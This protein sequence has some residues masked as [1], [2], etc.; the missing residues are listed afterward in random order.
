MSNKGTNG[1]K[2]QIIPERLY[3]G[4]QKRTLDDMPLAFACDDNDTDIKRL[5]DEWAKRS[6]PYGDKQSY[7]PP[8]VIPNVPISGFKIRRMIS[9][10]FIQKGGKKKTNLSVRI[11]DPRGF[12]LE[13]PVTNLHHLS[14]SC[15]IEEGVILDKCIWAIEPSMNRSN[16]KLRKYD[17]N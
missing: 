1:S 13:I 17:Q 16:I 12:L 11:E 2:A 14:V 6:S 15:N 9:H 8:T 7:L 10:Q 3:L 5:V 4:L